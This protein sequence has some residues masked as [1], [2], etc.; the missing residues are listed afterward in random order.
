MTFMLPF[1]S[2]FYMNYIDIHTKKHAWWF[3]GLFLCINRHCVTSSRNKPAL[4][5]IDRK[6][7]TKKIGTRKDGI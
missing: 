4:S 2:V 3:K 5:L 1:V 6:R 7:S